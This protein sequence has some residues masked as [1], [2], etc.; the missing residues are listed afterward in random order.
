M[1]A[2]SKEMIIENYRKLLMTH[3]DGPAV[4]QN[5]AEG[6]RF[7]A[8]KLM[9]I[10]NMSGAKILDLGCGV[11]DLLP[12]LQERFG[13]VKYTGIDIVPD[14]IENARIKY[15][16]ARFLCADVLSDNVDDVFDY[17]LLNG[18]FNNI[19]PEIDD[20]MRRMLRWAFAHALHGLGFNFISDRVNYRDESLAYH[21]PIA[22]LR[23]CMDELSRNVVMHHHYERCDVAVFVYRAS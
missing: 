15:P 23:F 1:D 5:S 22:M 9:K 2:K 12:A 8:D 17:V 13:S 16:D 19:Y 11:A 18:V 4:T 7:R 3:G 20:V 10:G 6:Q 21:D 14:F